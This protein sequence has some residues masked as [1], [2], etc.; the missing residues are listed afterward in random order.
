[1]KDPKGI[2]SRGDGLI[3]GNRDMK[4]PKDGVIDGA[5]DIKQP[6]TGI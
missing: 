6:W 5:R 3:G 2:I 1:M 4:D